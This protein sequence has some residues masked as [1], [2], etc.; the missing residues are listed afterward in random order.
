[1]VITIISIEPQCGY[2][3]LTP[4]LECNIP[5]YWCP[6]KLFWSYLC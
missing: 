6:I 5:K 2:G 3:S 4:Y 1:M